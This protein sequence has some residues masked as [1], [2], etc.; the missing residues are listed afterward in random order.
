MAGNVSMWMIMVGYS[1]SGIN[2][3]KTFSYQDWFGHPFLSDYKAQH[4]QG[5]GGGGEGNGG[6]TGVLE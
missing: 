1:Y 4:P 6:R 3:G 2:L 5:R